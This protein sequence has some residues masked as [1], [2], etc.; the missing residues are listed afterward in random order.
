[1]AHSVPR[2]EDARFGGETSFGFYLSTQEDTRAHLPILTVLLN[3]CIHVHY[4]STTNEIGD[5]VAFCLHR[6]WGLCQRLINV[7]VWACLHDV[8]VEP[9]RGKKDSNSGA[10]HGRNHSHQLRNLQVKLAGELWKG[11]ESAGA[12]HAPGTTGHGIG[13]AFRPLTG[14]HLLD[15][16]NRTELANMLGR[17]RERWA[18]QLVLYCEL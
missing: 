2:P 12:S 7:A 9:P 15:E 10:K 8:R 18:P 1:M 17:V 6:A 13:G 14:T 16:E 3:K 4:L 11:L 5:A